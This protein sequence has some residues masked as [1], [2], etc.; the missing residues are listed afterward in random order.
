[1]NSTLILNGLKLCH[2]HK[3]LFSV[4]QKHISEFG[5]EPPPFTVINPVLLDIEES[6]INIPDDISIPK[7]IQENEDQYFH[8]P[9]IYD[10]DEIEGTR[11][12]ASIANR[13]VRLAPEILQPGSTTLKLNDVL[14][15]EI[16][17]KGAYPSIL[18]FQNFPKSISTNVNNIACHGIP[19]DRPLEDGDIVSVDVNVFKDGFHG[20]CGSSII[21][22]QCQNDPLVR[23]IK[24]VSEELLFRGI[25]ACKGGGLFLDIGAEISK[26]S[27][28]RHVKVLPELS[29]HG[30]GKYLHETPEIFHVINDYPGLLKPG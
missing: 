25:S 7:F 10:K 28:K 24:T 18:G 12:A 17:S 19:D 2:A 11:L 8:K 4:F 22:G 26:F 20:I 6:K 3:R 23:Y 15:Q 9:N 29:G 27:R 16:L 5:I 1:M 30:I 21:V 13:C 14:H